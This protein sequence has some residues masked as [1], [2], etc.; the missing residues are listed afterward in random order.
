MPFDLAPHQT[1]AP[2]RTLNS[3]VAAIPVRW[4]DGKPEVL[5][6]TTRGRGA[7][8]VPKGWAL[9]DCLAAE[10]AEREAFEEAGVTGQ[11]EPYSLGTFEYWKKSKQGKVFFDVTAYALHVEHV[12]ADWPERA[13]RKRAWFPPDVAAQLT[14][15]PG[16]AELIR[17]AVRVGFKASPPVFAGGVLN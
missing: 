2:I 11:I 7:W 8:I 13:T 10:C 3:Q 16:L 15:N 6:I 17:S 14:G 1:H 5:L 12:V 9:M 4:V